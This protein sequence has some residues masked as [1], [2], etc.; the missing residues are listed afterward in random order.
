MIIVGFS[1]ALNSQHYI[2]TYNIRFVGHDSSVCI[3]ID[4]KIAYATEEERFNLKKHT[5]EIPAKALLDGLAF[6]GVQWED[7]DCFAFPWTNKPLEHL[8]TGGNHLLRTPLRFWPKIARAGWGVI[9]DTMSAQTALRELE[10]KIQKKTTAQIFT[11]DH[12]Q[13]HIA[14]SFLTSGFSEAAILSVD[15]SGGYLSALA[16]EWKNGKFNVF[17]SVKSPD[18]LGILYALLTEYLGF[19]SGFDEYKVMGMAAYG[20]PAVYQEKFDYLLK[21]KKF[22]YKTRYTA[23]ILNLPYCLGQLEKLFKLP[24]RSAEEEIRQEHFDVAAALQNAVEKQ[25][26]MMMNQLKEKTSCENLCLSGGVFQNSMANGKLLAKHA[27]RKIFIPP[28]PSDSGISLGAALQVALLHH[29]PLDIDP[30][31]LSYLGPEFDEDQYRAALHQYQDEIRF[32]KTDDP[33]QD[34]AELLAEGKIIAWFQGRMEYGARALGNRSILA[35][36]LDREVREKLNIF[37][38]NRENFRPFAASIL[39]EEASNYF[40]LEQNSPYMQFVVPIK[41]DKIPYLGAINHFDTCRIQTVHTKSNPVFHNL[42][43]QFGEKTGHPL[44]LNTSFNGKEQAIVCNPAQAIATFLDLG[45]D[46]LFLGKY[47]VGRKG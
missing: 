27:F 28:V 32:V 37:I 43:T 17:Y 19:R 18:S 1:G 5:A 6:C 22:G 12:H 45:L 34:A 35:S 10:N 30:L 25:L 8:K 23:S 15:G 47:W 3:L 14:S 16:G 4:G 11:V 41:K 39:A 36:P 44:L 24:Q 38:K 20:N 42:L 33:A 46:G 26:V 40:D 7:I 13:A 31:S 9:R 29:E 21:S 2:D